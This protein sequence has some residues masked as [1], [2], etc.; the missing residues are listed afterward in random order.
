MEKSMT[1]IETKTDEAGE[2][3]TIR[4]AITR[5]MKKRGS[6]R[7]KDLA[8]DL[9]LSEGAV[10]H[11]L[12]LLYSDGYARRIRR[13]VYQL[14]HTDD[15]AKAA[16]DKNSAAA[17]VASEPMTMPAKIIA[18]LQEAPDQALAFDT[19]QR[20]TGFSRQATGAVLSNLA[21]RGVV[22]RPRRGF[23]RLRYVPSPHGARAESVLRYITDRPWS[24]ITE[25][26]RGADRYVSADTVRKVLN[27]FIRRGV[28]KRDGFFYA[29][30]PERRSWREVRD[31]RGPA[32]IRR[33]RKRLGNV[34]RPPTTRRALLAVMK[35]YT[36]PRTAETLAARINLSLGA[37]RSVLVQLVN[38]GLVSATKMRS[39]RQDLRLVY[40]YQYIRNATDNS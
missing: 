33:N 2:K 1:L 9:E 19:M 24:R 31:N 12:H 16:S 6:C 40:H 38:D 34:G 15:S 26:Q 3:L 4:S 13:G 21:K 25:V 11:V 8:R 36:R 35:S 5:E 30:L 17:L 32:E 28:M 27:N 39:D 18:L 29:L 7:A 10:S 23:Y 22:A 37:I 14:G 20:A